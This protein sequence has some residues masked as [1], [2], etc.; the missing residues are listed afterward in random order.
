MCTCTPQ[1]GFSAGVRGLLQHSAWSGEAASFTELQSGPRCLCPSE[2]PSVA[3][4][5]NAGPARLRA[6]YQS[7]PRERGVPAAAAASRA[8]ALG[9][10][11]PSRQ[12]TAP[13]SPA[14]AL[15]YATRP[16]VCPQRRGPGP[17]SARPLRRPPRRHPAPPPPRTEAGRESTG[18]PPAPVPLPRRRCGTAAAPPRPTC[19]RQGGAR[20][21][22]PAPARS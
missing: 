15:P 22:P 4:A 1:T 11:S 19:S 13:T 21:G 9:D 8:G 6:G 16:A 20:P 14:P 12:A 7:E 2:L 17:G 3:P 5:A 18:R 10:T